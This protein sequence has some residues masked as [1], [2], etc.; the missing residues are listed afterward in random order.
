MGLVLSSQ[1]VT[2]VNQKRLR[3]MELG[4]NVLTYPTVAFN[5]SG[6]FGPKVCNIPLDSM[7]WRVAMPIIHLQVFK[8]ETWNR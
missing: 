7:T 8:L 2:P 6:F 5:T 1:V 3:M 4:G